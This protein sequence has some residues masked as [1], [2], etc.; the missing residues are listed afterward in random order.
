M[1]NEADPPWDKNWNRSDEG[2]P[3]SGSGPGAKRSTEETKQL[4]LEH[5]SG[6]LHLTRHESVPI[7]IDALLDWPTTREFTVQEFADHAGVVR[8]TVS[9][10]LGLLIEVGL[11]EELDDTRPQRYQIRESPTTKELFAF[12]SALNAVGGEQS[13]D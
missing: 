3:D 4:R 12:N 11:V 5:P 1:A 6:W 9:K 7:L 13:A 8:Q 2:A 10:Y